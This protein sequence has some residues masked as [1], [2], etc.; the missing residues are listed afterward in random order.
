MN[1]EKKQSRTNGQHSHQVGQEN[2][3]I[4][5]L[6]INAP[7]FLVSGITIVAFI[8]GALV[9]RESA[10]KT[11]GDLRVWVTTAF[12]W[13]FMITVSAMVLFC[14]FLIVSPL[15]KV[16]IGGRDSVPDY[17]RATWF[18]MLFAAGVGIG[19]MFFGVLEPVYY[20]QNPP[21]GIDPAD[22][23]AALAIGIGRGGFPLGSACLGHLRNRGSRP[24]V[25][26][27]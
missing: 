7:V 15:G 14:L 19:L 23:E 27:L 22:K 25:L 10:T 26:Y 17:S 21:L 5:G 4:L 9:F 8:V 13:L 3:Q 20:F 11:L 6:D 16:R 2:I 12:D 24:R 18:A 1:E